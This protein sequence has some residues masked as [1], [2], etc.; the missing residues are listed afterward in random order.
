MK[1][2]HKSVNAGVD[3]LCKL[4]AKMIMVKWNLLQ[5]DW[6]LQDVKQFMANKLMHRYRCYLHI[7]SKV[8]LD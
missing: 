3:N 1:K 2:F 8:L 6:L 5:N 7:I 4:R